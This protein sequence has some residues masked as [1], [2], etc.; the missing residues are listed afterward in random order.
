VLPLITRFSPGE[1]SLTLLEVNPISRAA[2]E[3]VVDAIEAGAYVRGVLGEDATVY[4]VPSDAPMHLFVAEAMQHA[5]TKEP[6]V[7]ICA[8]LA[9][10]LVKGG[11]MIPERVVVGAA[12]VDPAQEFD[13]LPAPDKKAPNR[14]ARIGL[15]T[16]FLLDLDYARSLGSPLPEALDT[17]EIDV[18]NRSLSGYQLVLT[19]EIDLYGGIELGE[20]ES[21]LTHPKALVHDVPFFDSGDRLIFH[22]RLAHNP[23]WTFANAREVSALPTRY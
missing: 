15:G 20:Y 16:V 19:T 7:A 23:S 12:M 14:P 2:V 10:Q 1:L 17:A 21:G 3:R 18:P 11:S 4:Q 9:R 6:H 22:F 8:N 5:L 13:S